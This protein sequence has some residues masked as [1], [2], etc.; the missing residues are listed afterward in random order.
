M[1]AVGF[2]DLMTM[3]ASFAVVIGLLVGTLFVIKKYGM[4][5]N[6]SGDRQ[7]EIIEVRNIGARQ[8]LLL[9]SIKSEKILIRVTANGMTKLG[10]WDLELDARTSVDADRI[11]PV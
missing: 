9:V 3:M 4:G 8:K 6:L 2:S 10:Q 7:I 1:E 11:D 5:M